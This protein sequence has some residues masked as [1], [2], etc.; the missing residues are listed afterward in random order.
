MLLSLSTLNYRNLAPGTLE[1]PAGVTAIYGE[2][3][4]G[5][6]NLLEAVYLGLTGQTNASKLEQL[7]QAGETEAYV[8]VDLQQD[9]ALSIQEI[10][11]GR[12]RRQ[13]KVDGVRVRTGDLPRGSAV[14]IRPEDSELV[15]G[16]PSGRRSYLD[17]LLSRISSRYSEYLSRY[18]RTIAQRN[19]ALRAGEQW[20][21]QV[22]N[23]TLVKL[24]VEIMSVRR[25]ALVRLSELATEANASLGSRKPLALTLNET[26]TPETYAQDLESR[27][28]EE[29]ARGSTVTGPH[30]DDLVLV[31]GDFAAVHYA[32]RG[33]GRTVALALRHAEMALLAEK[34]GEQPVLLI[35]DFTAELDPGR[36]QFLV[37]LAS[38][39][40]QAL[41]TGTECAPGA[42]LTLRA[43]AGRFTPE[44]DWSVGDQ[45]NEVLG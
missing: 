40:P 4:A 20:S 41:V 12:G 39:V 30:R 2:N 15:F 5:K 13:L 21:M 16:S 10:G 8:R 44:E 3:G 6:T 43:Q 35:D 1:F 42:A 29:L 11:L 26:T 31:L 27:I 34:F 7:V 17:S 37:D 28:N 24:G 9:G 25:R 45:S 14:W 18:E 22:W 38:S 23:E 36:R 19:A 32:S 33:E